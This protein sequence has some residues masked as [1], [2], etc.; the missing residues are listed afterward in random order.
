MYCA[1]VTYILQPFNLWDQ[2]VKGQQD[3]HRHGKAWIEAIALKLCNVVSTQGESHGETLITL[4]DG[5][6]PML[7]QSAKFWWSG[8]SPCP[9]NV[10]LQAIVSWQRHPS[11]C[12]PMTSTVPNWHHLLLMH[13]SCFQFTLSIW[14]CT[15][16]SVVVHHLNCNL[17][18]ST[19][20]DIRQHEWNPKVAIVLLYCTTM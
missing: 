12:Q 2:G 3:K 15:N 17:T 16:L 1:G 11:F 6:M 8:T 13:E 4:T 19:V 9:H 10:G 14:R 7:L 5:L 18:A 20:M